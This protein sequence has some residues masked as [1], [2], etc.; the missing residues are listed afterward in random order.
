MTKREASQRRG[1]TFSAS[2]AFFAVVVLFSA[3]ATDDVVVATL[4]ADADA[5][6]VPGCTSNDDCPPIAFCARQSCGDTQGS[7]QL[8]PVLCDDQGPPTCGCDGVSYWNDCLR[9]QYGAT[10]SIPGSCASGPATCM[11][12]NAL[13]CPVLGAACAKLFSPGVA[14]DEQEL[15]ACWV[16]PVECPTMTTPDR[17]RAC[18]EPMTDC[19]DT[20]GAIRSG[21][22]YR[23]DLMHEC[24]PLP[25]GR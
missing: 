24:M 11:D 14:C 12:D 23:H 21:R 17:W 25:P 9:M 20:C 8:R 6:E 1:G 22:P 19:R 7:C 10:S 13:D 15:G 18:S 3:C 5:S 16:L 2:G 4:P